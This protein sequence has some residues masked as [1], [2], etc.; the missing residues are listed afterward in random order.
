MKA[1]AAAPKAQTAPVAKAIEVKP[2]SALEYI[3]YASFENGNS[4]FFPEASYTIDAKSQAQLKKLASLLK[5]NKNLF[6]K[7]EVHGYADISGPEA[8][9]Q[10]LSEKRAEQV[11]A[12]LIKGGLNK[13][14]IV[15]LGKGSSQSKEI[16]AQDRKVELLFTGVK[17]EKAL[18]KALAL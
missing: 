18:Q 8:L 5:Q 14:T 3:N 7:V 10:S 13:E 17:D 6:S 1:T 11:K 4:I 16:L 15:A 12:Q 9:N 2:T